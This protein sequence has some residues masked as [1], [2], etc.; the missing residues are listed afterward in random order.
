MN[1]NDF[2]DKENQM[3][4]FDLNKQ[5]IIYRQDAKILC[6]IGFKRINHII[7][8]TKILQ[9]YIYNKVYRRN[10][11]EMFKLQHKSSQVSHDSI[12]EEL[13]NMTIK[14]IGI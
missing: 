2:L 3:Y 4:Y 9:K 7:G 12:R 11:D 8:D 1:L 14:E 10:I 5:K 6:S 13:M